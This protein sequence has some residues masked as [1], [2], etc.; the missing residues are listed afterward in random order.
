MIFC[1]FKNMDL[2][3]NMSICYSIFVFQKWIHCA[4]CYTLSYSCW[5]CLV[6]CSSL[7][8]WWRISECGRWPTRSCSPWPLVILWWLL[9]ACP[10]HLF[11]TCWRISSLELQCARLWPILW[12][13]WTVI[14]SRTLVN[15][16]SFKDYSLNLQN[17]TTSQIWKIFFFSLFSLIYPGAISIK[18][19]AVECTFKLSHYFLCNHTFF[20]FFEYCWNTFS[21]NCGSSN[22]SYDN[23]MMEKKHYNWIDALC[24]KVADAV[25]PQWLRII[26]W[27]NILDTQKY[28]SLAEHNL[29]GSTYGGKIT[30]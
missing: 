19:L 5:A 8:F 2:Y 22:S 11:P 6:I 1:Y 16:T 29:I 27:I 28:N 21:L 18:M 26:A 4:Y 25:Q 17:F 13:R 30:T 10:S 24:S 9:S 23:Q 14:S 15:I 20:N 12:V 3:F 7:W